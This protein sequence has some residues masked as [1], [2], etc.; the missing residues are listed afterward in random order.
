MALKRARDENLSIIV[1]FV[2]DRVVFC[3]FEGKRWRERC[4]AEG[5]TAAVLPATSY[6]T[7]ARGLAEWVP[8][9]RGRALA[10]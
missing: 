6:K 2:V 7:R 8:L 1:E 5:G 3:R 9:S 10:T 4:V